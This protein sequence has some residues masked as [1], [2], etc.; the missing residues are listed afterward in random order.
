MYGQAEEEREKRGRG[1]G[2]FSPAQEA[3]NRR[4]VLAGDRHKHE[5]LLL[6]TEI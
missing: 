1:K 5:L 6:V 3:A 2:M 4:A